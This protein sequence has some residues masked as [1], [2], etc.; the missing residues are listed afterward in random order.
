MDGYG[1]GYGYEYRRLV[2]SVSLLTPELLAEVGRMVVERGHR[3]AGK[4]A[5]RRVARPPSFLR[6]RDRRASSDRPQPAD[7]RGAVH[8]PGRVPGLRGA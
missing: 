7:G 5:W 8:G 6:G 4:K 1:Y 3:V 2:D